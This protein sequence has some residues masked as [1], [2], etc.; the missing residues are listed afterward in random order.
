[1]KKPIIALVIPAYNEARNL[2]NILAEIRMLQAHRKNF[3][4]KPIV[5]DDGSS[6]DTQEVMGEY[7]ERQ[8]ILYVKHPRNL[9]IGKTVQTGFRVAT[10][11][12]KA[13]V[14]IQLDG[15][16]Q[17]PP[18]EVMKL[19]EP[20]LDGHADV[21]IGS[22]YLLGGSGNVSNKWRQVGTKFFS[23]L[24]NLLVA[25]HIEDTTSG[26]RAFNIEAAKFIANQYPEDYPEVQAYI[27][28][29]RGGFEIMEVPVQM[30]MRFEGTS[31]ITPLKSGLYM[32]KVTL[33]TIL[34]RFR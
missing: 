25:V 12:L 9:G 23:K 34:E 8:E 2:P 3:T 30:R 27:A 11:V 10:R 15:D 33:A 14:T 18:Y 29:A 28:L 7:L 5:V 32:A 24:I 19:V 1:M 4:F 26:F 22:R 21:V 17:H 16:G 31:S 13:D 6:D 20:I